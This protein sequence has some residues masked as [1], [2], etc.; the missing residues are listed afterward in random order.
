MGSPEKEV[1]RGDARAALLRLRLALALFGAGALV[2]GPWDMLW[3]ME[4]AFESFF[5]PPHLFIYGLS[6]AS[7]AIVASVLMDTRLRTAFG[8][9][10]TDA[11]GP[12]SLP[13]A[14]LFLAGGLLVVLTSGVLDEL[15]HGA[16]GL[17]ETRLSAPH[18]MFGWGL[19][20]A[21]LGFG[22]ARLALAPRAPVGPAEALMFA[23][24]A[25]SFSLYA[26]LLPF[27]V[28]STDTTLGAIAGLPVIQAQPGAAHTFRIYEAW[29]IERANAVFA[30]LAALWGGAA[31]VLSG[32]FDGRK[33]TVVASA[34]FATAAYAA[35]WYGFALRLG[36]SADLRTWIPP[37][38]LP[39][40]L[41]LALGAR[42]EWPG[43]RSQWLGSALFAGLTVLAWPP[44]VGAGGAGALAVV[45]GLS[46]CAFKGGIILMG[47][48]GNAVAN[49]N[50]PRVR[51][52][53]VALGFAVPLALGL[54]DL[55]MRASVA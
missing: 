41:V 4:H 38:A 22:S 47:A 18:A 8:G 19:L 32:L 7:M 15:W 9:A 55:R 26:F 48:V 31:F 12:L 33:S 17:D 50:G 54:V 43:P 51:F 10:E 36:L 11:K 25:L 30:P 52:V 45:F 34:A 29:H 49:P 28:Y 21:L 24:L 14:L 53:V 35:L 27:L 5:S 16:F 3:H 42:L 44:A 39:A 23:V 6:A 13:P 40:F 2:G 20:V 1:A 46:A 37:P